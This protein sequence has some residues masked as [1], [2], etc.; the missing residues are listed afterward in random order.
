[1]F[2]RQKV[3]A[4]IVAAGESSRMGGIDKMF[5]PL[6]GKP[7]LARV[8]AAFETAPSVDRIA[9]VLNAHNIERGRRL[10]GTEHWQKVDA[11]VPGGALR[12]DSVKEG[13][14][15]LGD[16]KWILVH[17]G[18]RPLVTVELI[19]AGLKA[20]RETGAAICAVPVTDTIKLESTQGLVV[21]T[22][23]RERLRAV[24]TPQVFR[25]DI[26]KEACAQD[27]G[28]ATDDASLVEALGYRVKIYPGDYDNIKL[29]TPADLTVAEVLWRRK[30]C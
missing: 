29:T 8:V 4:I 24:Q 26:I 15:K 9:L 13:L 14:G 19:E 6:A 20:A 22:L 3:G 12:Q 21:R 11:I 16:C 27:A 18:A 2:N 28:E 5:A 1:M 7:V 23:K 25:S 30:G 10:A 17:D